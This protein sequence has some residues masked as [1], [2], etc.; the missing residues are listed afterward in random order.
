MSDIIGAEAACWAGLLVDLLQKYCSGHRTTAHLHWFL[1]LRQ[2]DLNR[3]VRETPASG[4]GTVA[5]QVPL[6]VDGFEPAD[7]SGEIENQAEVPL[8]QKFRLF[9]DLGVIKVPADYDPLTWLDKFEERYRSKFHFYSPE[10]TSTKFAKTALKLAPGRKFQV[11]VFHQVSW[12]ILTTDDERI[13]FLRSQQAVFLGAYGIAL[14]WKKMRKQLIGDLIHPNYQSFDDL[15]LD[16]DDQHR[17]SVHL[18][19]GTDSEHDDFQLGRHESLQNR[20]PTELMLC[21]SEVE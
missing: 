11:R 8:D 19:L 21:F 20:Y 9:C 17:S 3:L 2:E 12:G 16:D 7:D 5:S 15:W 18:S 1:N 6:L 13:E 10:I 14:A 4:S